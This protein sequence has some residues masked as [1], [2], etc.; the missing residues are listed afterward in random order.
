MFSNRYEIVKDFTKW[1]VYRPRGQ[2]V[3]KGGVYRPH[4]KETINKDT[5]FHPETGNSM[6]KNSFNYNEGNSSDSY[7]DSIDLDS[8]EKARSIP[9]ADKKEAYMKMIKWAEDKRGFKFMNILKQFKA[10][11]NAVQNDIQPERIYTRWEEMEKD[12]F[13]ISKGFDFMD[14]VTSFNKRA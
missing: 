8:G 6:K 5:G 9:K 4:T 11:S 14:V 3:R 2:S 7:E 12:K 10:L 13:W 1:G